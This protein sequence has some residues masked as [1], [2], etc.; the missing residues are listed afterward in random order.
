MYISH[1]WNKLSTKR[2][3]AMD[4]NFLN[5]WKNAS[6]DNSLLPNSPYDKLISQNQLAPSPPEDYADSLAI[7]QGAPRNNNLQAGEVIT[8]IEVIFESLFDCIINE[9]KCLVLHIKSR[10]GNGQQTIDAASG[11]IRNTRNVETKEI[12]FPGKT[13]KEAW[14]FAALLRILELSHEALV[15]GIVTTKRQVI[16]HKST[17]IILPPKPW[18]ILGISTEA[19]RHSACHNPVP[20]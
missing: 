11:A 16:S 13:Q 20:C 9:K 4:Y 3:P 2:Y 5:L 14:K 18:D 17:L 10:G 1:Q 15:T 8:K 6:S 19:S 12:T 7:S